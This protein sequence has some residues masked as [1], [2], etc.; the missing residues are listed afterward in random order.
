[1]DGAEGIAS[2][3]GFA[4]GDVVSW[5]VLSSDFDE[6]LP[7]LP[8][9]F[10][11]VVESA[12]DDDGDAEL[13]GTIARIV[14]ATGRRKTVAYDITATPAEHVQVL[15]LAGFLVDVDPGIA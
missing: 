9:G 8:A 2:D 13:N 4:I 15:D 12:A 1:M 11:G 7:Q 3:D 6:L 14:M 10:D 5:S